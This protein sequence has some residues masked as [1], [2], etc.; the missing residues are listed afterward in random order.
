MGILTEMS[1]F[2][3]YVYDKRGSEDSKPTFNERERK[4]LLTAREQSF[5]SF[6]YLLTSM[7]Y[8]ED[9]I[10]RISDDEW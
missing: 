8:S 4:N 5:I 2:C 9:Q 3:C 7:F 10:A 6:R 1:Y